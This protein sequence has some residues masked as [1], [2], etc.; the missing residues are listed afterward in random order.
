MRTPCQ[1][2][3]EAWVGEDIKLRAEA[4]ALCLTC[5][6]LDWCKKHTAEFK[7]EHGVWAGR[8]YSRRSAT[9]D[10]IPCARNGCDNE[11]EQAAVGAPRRYCSDRCRYI[12]VGQQP[13][14]HGTEGGY[15]THKRRGEQA[16]QACKSAANRV[17]RERERLARERKER[18]A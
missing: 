14:T 11:F 13:I 6:A 10:P 16:C 2:A 15:Q 1:D 8:D 9:A 7:P 17:K 3:P 5:P 4:A 12:A 18:A